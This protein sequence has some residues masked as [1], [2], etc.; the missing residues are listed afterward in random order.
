MAIT[1]YKAKGGVR[2]RAILYE[3]KRILASKRGFLTKRDAKKWMTDAAAELT[4]PVQPT[5]TGTDFLTVSNEYL[6]DMFARRQPNT[7]RYKKAV[8]ESLIEYMG[9]KSFM[10]EDLTM[11]D[12]SAF[13]KARWEEEGAK[14]AN[15]DV[16]EFKALW[17]WLI[18]KKQ[19]PI[20]PVARG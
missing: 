4:R 6:D 8:V 17:N 15:R 5:P 16:V 7:Y 2:Y 19:V 11:D 12:I 3:G 18:K 13:L 9:G 14:A 20:E 10:L 1:E